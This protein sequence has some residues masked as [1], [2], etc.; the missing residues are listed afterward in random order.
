[1]NNAVEK[2]Y[3]EYLRETFY[4]AKHKSGL[5]IVF[6]PKEFSSYY[7]ILGVNYGSVDNRFKPS[8][9]D[10]FLVMPDGIAHY[11]EH[12][13]FESENGEDAFYRFS[14]FGANSNAFT[15]NNLTAYLFSCTSNFEDNL[16]ILLDFVRTPYFTEENVEKERGIISEEIEMYE[17]DPYT[18]L[19]YGMLE[20]LY[21]EHPIR[22]NIAG[23]VESVGG[24]TPEDLYRCYDSFYTLDNMILSVSG[25]TDIDTIL[26][27]CDRLFDRTD[28]VKVE[29]AL[30]SE[31][32]GVFR[33]QATR[34]MQVSNPLF[35]IGIK[36][37][38]EKDSVLRAKRTVAAS[39]IVDAL[40]GPSSDFFSRLYE[41]GYVNS[42]SCG[43]DSMQN[44]AFSYIIGESKDA[45]YIYREFRA[46]VEQAYRNGLPRDDFERIKKVSIANFVKNYDSTESIATDAVYLMFDGIRPDKYVELLID[47][48]YEFVC[49]V[50]RGFFDE[51]KCAMMNVLPQRKD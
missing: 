18:A 20:L 23:S 22:R 12:K 2:V 44:Y 17:D 15:T 49:E 32:E 7:A 4:Y 48:D 39:I 1:M 43:Y 25:N 6:V 31:P 10:D 8:D 41:D 38:V 30:I 16:E 24:I 36:D 26:G 5:Q 50:M 46:V 3:S 13:M 21:K 14:K 51:H 37:T 28:S 33:P 47:V 19:H 9:E 29:R 27:V 40:F 35:C 11:L 42:M 34:Y 45:Q